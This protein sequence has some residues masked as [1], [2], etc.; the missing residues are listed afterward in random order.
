MLAT[1]STAICVTARSEAELEM[2]RQGVDKICSLV[3]LRSLTE[4]RN[5]LERR[6]RGGAEEEDV[7]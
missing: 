5:D 1:Q 7:G 6:K 3:D 4:S 2:N